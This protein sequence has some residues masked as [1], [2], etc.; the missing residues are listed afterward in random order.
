MVS[1]AAFGPGEANVKLLIGKTIMLHIVRIPLN[2]APLH[3][4]VEAVASR[5]RLLLRA[6]THGGG[7]HL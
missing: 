4:A 3:Q 7:A 2:K 5:L 6:Q 1:Y